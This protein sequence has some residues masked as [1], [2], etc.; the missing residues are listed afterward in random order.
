MQLAQGQP[1]VVTQAVTLHA[2]GDP[3]ANDYEL[4]TVGEVMLEVADRLV[5]EEARQPAAARLV[6]ALRTL[7]EGTRMVGVRR[8]W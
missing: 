6:G 3:L 2:F 7:T 5:A 8:P 4:Y 1:D